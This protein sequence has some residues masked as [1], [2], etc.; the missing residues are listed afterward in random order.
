[1]CETLSL[2]KFFVF[3]D[4]NAEIRVFGQRRATID[5]AGLC[6]H[7]DNLVGEKVAAAIVSNHSKESAKEHIASIREKNPNANFDEIIKQ[8]TEG[9]IMKGFGIVKLTRT[10]DNPS[11]PFE[12]EMRNPIVKSH[13]G[14]AVKFIL[15]YW[16]SALSI[17]LKETLDI[18][19]ALFDPDA[20][21]LKCRF[22]VVGVPAASG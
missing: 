18:T 16:A 4:I 8:L 9:E 13:K 10:R 14:T 12:F 5:L 1:M 11:V 3:D 17:L 21:A 19:D 6:K 2:K 22:T 15:S 20:N 7:L